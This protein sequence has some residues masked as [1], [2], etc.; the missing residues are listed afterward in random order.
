MTPEAAVKGMIAVE[1]VARAVHISRRTGEPLPIAQEHVD[2]FQPTA[3]KNVSAARTAA[4][5]AG[6]T[7]TEQE[8]AR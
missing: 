8:N 6:T 5:A 1:E 3:T 2:C 7:D 4:P